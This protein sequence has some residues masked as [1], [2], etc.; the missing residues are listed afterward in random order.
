MLK[1]IDMKNCTCQ[2]CGMPMR[3]PEIYGTGRDG[4]PIEDYCVY[5]YKDGGFTSD[6]TMDEMMQLCSNY[7]EGNSRDFYIASMRTLYPHLKRWA[8][9]EDTQSEYYKSINN[10]M[11]YVQGH[12]DEN[13]DLKT[14]AGIACISPYHFHRIFKAV[15]GESLAEYVNR[16]RMEYV[17]GQLKASGLSLAELAER[18]GYSSEQALSRAFKK[19]FNLPPK[20]FKAS[21]FREVFH[22]ELVPRICKVASKN[23]ITLR[24]SESGRQEWQRLYMY[25][26]VNRLMS[27]VT[28]SIEVIRNDQYYPALT[29]R[30]SLKANSHIEPC[31]LQEGLYAIF[32]HKGDMDRIHELYMAVKNYWLPASKYSEGTGTPY[33]VFLNN[34]NMVPKEEIL[35]EIYV[36]LT[37]GKLI[38][39][40]SQ[41]YH[42]IR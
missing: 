36:P 11:Q 27:D 4:M 37:A 34:P 29:T 8:K 2:S 33:V 1:S 19:Y 18:T 24:N 5:C 25:A 42:K 9:K 10:V 13:T 17:A 23:I 6:V 3:V 7:V 40:I 41:D 38:P 30:E 26:V 32:T 22:D 12:L 15:I 16:L 20:V 14:L 21:Y 35:T 39:V 31:V 28:E